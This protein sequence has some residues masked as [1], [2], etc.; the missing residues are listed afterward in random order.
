MRVTGCFR[1]Y[2]DS[3]FRGNDDIGHDDGMHDSFAKVSSIGERAH[4]FHPF[5]GLTGMRGCS[6][7]GRAPGL[8]PGG[9]RFDTAQLH[10]IKRLRQG[11]YC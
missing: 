3:R 2:V 9:R 11:G 1:G 7:A 4:V 10:Q 8:Q 5:T 6:S